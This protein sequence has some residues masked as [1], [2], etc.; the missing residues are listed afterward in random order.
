M[1]FCSWA[2]SL[3][4]GGARLSKTELLNDR[5]RLKPAVLKWNDVWAAWCPT[6][7]QECMPMPSGR[8]GFCETSLVG[9]PTREWDEPPL[10]EGRLFVRVTRVMS[11]AA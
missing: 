8:C 1:E 6:C 4:D 5:T 10:K 9:Q 7:L 2:T 3:A 11:H